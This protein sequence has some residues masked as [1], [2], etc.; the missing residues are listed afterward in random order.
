MKLNKGCLKK[1]KK[2][3]YHDLVKG[4]NNHIIQSFKTH[5]IRTYNFLL[6][7]DTG[8]SE[9]WAKV[10]KTIKSGKTQTAVLTIMLSLKFII[11][12][13]SKKITMFM[14]SA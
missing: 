12:T 7:F 13:V 3:A 11:F 5:V 6:M 10:D 1:K 9:M 4:I 2:V 8:Y 14:F